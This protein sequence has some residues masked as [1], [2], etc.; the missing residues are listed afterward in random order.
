M[1]KRRILEYDLIASGIPSKLMLCKKDSLD[2]RLR[3]LLDKAFHA[4]ASGK[5]VLLVE[6]AGAARDMLCVV[7]AKR[8]MACCEAASEVMLS[9]F[10]SA[11]MDTFAGHTFNES[12]EASE[13]WNR[14]TNAKYLLLG[15]MDGENVARKLYKSSISGLVQ[16]RIVHNVPTFIATGLTAEDILSFYGSDVS[17]AVDGYFEYVSSY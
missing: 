16:D 9:L 10:Q 4:L 14:F 5:H 1:R 13:D 15:G 3:G 17:R 8:L 12:M 2:H 7:L 6:E 11:L